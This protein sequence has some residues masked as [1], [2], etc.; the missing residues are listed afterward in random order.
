M[1]LRARCRELDLAAF[2]ERRA[3]PGRHRDVDARD[4]LNNIAVAELFSEARAHFVRDCFAVSSRPDGMAFVVGQQA[5]F[6]AAEARFPGEIIIGSGLF[7][8]G[9]SS[10]RFGQALFN[11]GRCT[12]IAEAVLVCAQNGRSAPFPPGF[13]EHAG[14]FLMAQGTLPRQLAPLR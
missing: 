13:V 8:I 1:D 14:R 9:G 2:P 3:I 12:A 10:L 4:H 7:A 5:V 11:D 6:Y